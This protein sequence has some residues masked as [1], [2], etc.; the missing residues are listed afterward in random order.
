MARHRPAP[1]SPASLAAA[2]HRVDVA[3][4]RVAATPGRRRRHR[5]R[6]RRA[7][8]QREAAA[9]RTALPAAA[10]PAPPPSTWSPSRSRRAA[11]CTRPWTTPRARHREANDAAGR[12]ADFETLFMMVFAAVMAGLLFRRFE[13]ARRSGELGCRGG[14]GAG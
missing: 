4:G 5:R 2:G 11:G 7:D 12:V 3:A 14:Q 13:A 9:A 6:R 10:P 8:Y 1:P